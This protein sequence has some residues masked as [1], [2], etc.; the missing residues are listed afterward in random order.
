MIAFYRILLIRH[1]T[2]VN[3]GIGQNLLMRVFLLG[4]ICLAL[5]CVALKASD[6]YEQLMNETCMLIPSLPIF[7]LLDEYERSRGNSSIYFYWI[8]VQSI[9]NLVMFCMAIAELIIYL[10]FFFHLYLHDNGKMSRRLIAPNIIKQRNKKNAITFYGHFC[11]FAFEVCFLAFLMM[12]I[13][14]GGPG[15]GLWTAMVSV[16]M[17]SFACMSII[18]VTTSGTLR[19]H[20]FRF[21]LYNL[22]FGLK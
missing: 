22:I 14:V 2:W 6:D 4:G 7:W 19:A 1:N 11:S 20:V 18:E 12:A 13:S 16:R 9:I 21:S 15:N 3:C 17:V 5:V 8:G 10:V